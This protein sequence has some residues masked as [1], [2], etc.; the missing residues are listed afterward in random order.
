MS[1]KLNDSEAAP[2]N[3]IADD[4]LQDDII[5]FQT[6][7]VEQRVLKAS[8]TDHFEDCFFEWYN[9]LRNIGCGA[10]NDSA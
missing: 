3:L 6:S 4:A 7:A 8:T 10:V 2:D 5:A 1:R 9:A